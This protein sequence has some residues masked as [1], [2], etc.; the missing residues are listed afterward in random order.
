MQSKDNTGLT[1]A[2]LGVG[3]VGGLYGGLLAKAGFS[4]HFLARSDAHHLR[5]NGLR[6]ESLLGDFSLNPI[7][8]YAAP[9]DM[10]KV[11]CVLVT[12]KATSNHRLPT[13]LPAICGPETIVI[14]VQNGLEVERSAAEVVGEQQVLG[15]CAFL[16]CNK[17]G[18][19]HIK[20][21]DYGKI[22]IGEYAPG[23]T[24]L[25]TDRLQRITEEF[26]ASGIEIEPTANLAEVRWKKLAWNI[27]F[28]G[29][30]VVLHADTS[31]VMGHPDS[32]RLA[33]VLMREVV[34]SARAG[35]VDIPD[36]FIQT[37]MDYTR[38][39]V[40]YASSMLLDYQHQ[41]PLELE[42]IFE[43]PIRLA[44]KSGY[45]PVR[46]EMLHQQLKFLDWQ[47]RNRQ[48]TGSVGGF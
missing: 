13:I 30:S 19:G 31:A 11:D 29:L 45:D 41:R 9:Q 4:V 42:A 1:Y 32:C 24:G 7:Q 27:P 18:P 25:V 46:V 3:A 26:R 40:P 16:C 2:V 6:V 12:W 22:V 17:V 37:N 33:E 43:T 44:K 8:V 15:A 36:G 47:N 23:L 34:E 20:H 21:V 39:M 38:N 14:M 10:P 48:S 28:N 35:G 5:E